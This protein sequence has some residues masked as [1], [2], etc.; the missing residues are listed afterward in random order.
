MFGYQMTNEVLKDY[1]VV[2]GARMIW[3]NPSRHDT[4]TFSLLWDRQ[5]MSVHD[6]GVVELDSLTAEHQDKVNA[7]ASLLNEGGLLA[8]LRCRMQAEALKGN[9][10]YREG[11][12]IELL[13]FWGVHAVCN[14]NSS[15][16]YVYIRVGI[17]KLD[18][19]PV[20][21]ALEELEDGECVWSGSLLPRVGETVEMTHD[22]GTGTVCSYFIEHK[23]LHCMV[24]GGKHRGR[25]I[26]SCPLPSFKELK[27]T[28][29]EFQ[30][31]NERARYP[32]DGM[33]WVKKQYEREGAAIKVLLPT[34]WHPCAAGYYSPIDFIDVTN[35]MGR[36]WQPIKEKEI[37]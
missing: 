21:K 16:G 12:E 28:W 37:A 20:Q 36:E 10:D 22:R 34:P 17:R 2:W 5:S 29:F 15:H 32:D 23:H 35:I 26:N 18:Q 27:T 24:Q 33:E 6:G 30:R 3:E 11:K 9:L 14:T 1:E 8:Y 25:E 31:C 4:P 7:M 13:D 19:L